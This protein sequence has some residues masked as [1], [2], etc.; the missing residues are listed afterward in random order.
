MGLLPKVPRIRVLSADEEELSNLSLPTGTGDIEKQQQDGD[1]APPNGRGILFYVSLVSNFALLAAALSFDINQ[2]K[3]RRKI[4]LRNLHP[5]QQIFYQY[6][7]EHK[8]FI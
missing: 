6:F 7:K 8:H 5:G 4:S 1:A 2:N 3:R